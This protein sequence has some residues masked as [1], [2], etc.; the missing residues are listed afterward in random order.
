MLRVAEEA[1]LTDTGRLRRINEDS[2]LARSPLFVVADGMGGARAGEV[3]SRT[4]TEAFEHW[5]TEAADPELAL[6]QTVQEANRRINTIAREDSSRAGMGTTLTAALVGPNAVTIAH[7]GDSRA[8]MYRDGT[9]TRLTRDHSLVEEL[10]RRG[11]LTPEEA[12]GHPQRS[13]IT[14]ALGPEPEVAVDTQQSF[15]R[16]GDIFLLCSDGLTTMVSEREIAETLAQTTDLASAVRRLIDMANSCGGKDNITTVAF[17]IAAPE[18]E[19]EEFAD[20][21]EF[22]VEA[23]AGSYEEAPATRPTQTLASAGG[24]ATQARPAARSAPAPGLPARRRRRAWLFG[25]IGLGA[26]IALLAGAYLGIRQAYF[27][28]IDGQGFVTVYRGVPYDLPAGL[29]LYWSDYRTT[30]PAGQLLPAEAQTIREHKLRGR[31]DAMDLAG[32]Y[33]TE[34]QEPKSELEAGSNKKRGATSRGNP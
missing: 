31:T 14:R 21:R 24:V 22:A 16:D 25:A 33:E 10:R 15:A 32:H 8:Y 30:V 3:A 18:G 23:A 28:G 12:E 29:H 7:V 26:V 34:H 13:I 20:T 4:A 6:S 1:A 11:Q 5:V 17:R 27:L 9:L 19:T 2:Y